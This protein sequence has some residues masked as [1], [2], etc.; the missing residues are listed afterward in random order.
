M[1]KIYEM[2][3]IIES[4]AEITFN[5][6]KKYYSLIKAILKIKFVKRGGKKYVENQGGI[7]IL[8]DR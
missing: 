7:I 8:W 2:S 1:L 5:Q 4:N 3:V 6:T